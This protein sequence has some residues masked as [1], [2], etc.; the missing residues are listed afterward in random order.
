MSNPTFE[1]SIT[2]L[3]TLKVIKNRAISFGQ[4]IEVFLFFQQIRETMTEARVVLYGP[5]SSTYD[6]P[7]NSGENIDP[8]YQLNKAVVTQGRWIFYDGQYNKQ[9]KHSKL[10]MEGEGKVDLGFICESA[11]E[12]EYKADGI[13]LFEHYN[14]CGKMQVNVNTCTLFCT[15]LT[16]YSISQVRRQFQNRSIQ[17]TFL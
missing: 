15:F 4:L 14:Y 11:R 5:S 13:C 16:A 10:V 6:I 1:K 12:V 2:K 9:C 7:P 3:G 17:D 8:S